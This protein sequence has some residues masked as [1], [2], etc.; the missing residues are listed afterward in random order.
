MRT[1]KYTLH[2]IAYRKCC[3]YINNNKR[4]NIRTDKLLPKLPPSYLDDKTNDEQ[5]YNNESY[6]IIEKKVMNILQNEWQYTIDNERNDENN[7][8]RITYLLVVSQNTEGVVFRRG[9]IVMKYIQ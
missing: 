9:V 2:V 6:G 5:C 7:T 3:I 1:A 8:N 4:V